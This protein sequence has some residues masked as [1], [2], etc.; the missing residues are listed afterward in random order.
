[1]Y[2]SCEAVAEIVL[3]PALVSVAA[4]KFPRSA[5]KE[6]LYESLV[7]KGSTGVVNAV[8]KTTFRCLLG[9]CGNVLS[10]FGDFR[11]HNGGHFLNGD[12]GTAPLESCG[13]CRRPIP[14][15]T[16]DLAGIGRRQT[17]LIVS[18]YAFIYS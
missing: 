5:S 7:T 12:F 1:L 13:Y 11:T 4:I 9:G 18:I 15:I 6:P 17:P 8:P 2:F 10:I 14:T 3:K 16:I